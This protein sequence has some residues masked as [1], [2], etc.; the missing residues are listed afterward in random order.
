MIT[1][2]YEVTCDRCS[3][4]AHVMPTAAESRRCVAEEG[5]HLGKIEPHVPRWYDC[6]KLYHGAIAWLDKYESVDGEG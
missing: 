2:W 6:N 4:G 1:R 3:L 5:T